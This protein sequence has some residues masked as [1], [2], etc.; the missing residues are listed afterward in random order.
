MIQK[1][2]GFDPLG[3][4]ARTLSEC[5]VIQLQRQGRQYSLESRIA[6][7]HLEELGRR[8][9]PEIAKQLRVTVADVQEAAEAI[10]RLEPKPGRPFSADEEQ[11]ILPD[12]F[13]EQDGGRL[14][15]LAER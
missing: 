2:Q 4:A 13:V 6:Q 5:L 1:V 11:T 7:H 14:H 9:F 10:A 12:V 8:K 15:R 3:V